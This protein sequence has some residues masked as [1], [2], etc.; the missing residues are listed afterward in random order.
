MD[1]EQQKTYAERFT[2]VQRELYSKSDEAFQKATALLREVYD[3]SG[4]LLKDLRSE[5]D[6][7]RQT[8]EQQKTES[9][10]SRELEGAFSAIRSRLA[11]LKSAIGLGET[12]GD[13]T[14]EQDGK[15]WHERIFSSFGTTYNKVTTSLAFSMGDIL[16]QAKESGF[17]FA[18]FLMP[19]MSLI[20]I[21]RIELASALRAEEFTGIDASKGNMAK[22][23]SV[24]KRKFASEPLETFFARVA[25]QARET[26]PNTTAISYT[27]LAEAAEQL[28]GENAATPATPEEAPPATPGIQTG[29][30]LGQNLDVA[31]SLLTVTTSGAITAG[32]RK[33]QLRN[34]EYGA[35]TVKTAAISGSKQ[36]TITVSVANQNKD[37][38]LSLTEQPLRE[39]VAELSGDAA[40]SKRT[41]TAADN[42][43][44]T[45]ELLSAS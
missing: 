45:F 36:L 10:A 31:G 1:V 8:F 19:V 29:N 35:V 37:Y 41:F 44:L 3:N 26:Y 39:F 42:T 22:L 15:K 9:A 14:K 32:S 25:K 30:L 5:V 12:Q 4:D 23:M 38:N 28:S 18:K 34:D 20:G 24:H 27:D 17:S 6:L 40:P 33:W 21:N 16:K 43:Q 11:E 13:S 7:L 2:E